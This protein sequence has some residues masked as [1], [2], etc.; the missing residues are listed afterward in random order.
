VSL[1]G[2]VQPNVNLESDLFSEFLCGGATVWRRDIL[3]SYSFDESF[4]GYALW[5]DVDYSLRVSEKW[6]LLVIADAKVLHLHIDSSAT[7]SQTMIGDVEI[8][9]R[10]HFYSKHRDRLNFLVTSW[11]GFG[12]LLKNLYLFAKGK[13]VTTERLLANASALARCLQG[14][15]VRR[16]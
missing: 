13:N 11:A 10:F 16:S 6:K 7:R 14:R 15:Y 8:V 4:R 5:E 9:D 2:S 12:T 1:G 3:E